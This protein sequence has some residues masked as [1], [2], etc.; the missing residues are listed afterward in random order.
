MTSKLKQFFV[1]SRYA[2]LALTSLVCSVG[3]FGESAQSGKVLTLAV[4]IPLAGYSGSFDHF[5]YDRSRH[6][7][8]LAAEDH[9]TVDVFA[10]DGGR[11]LAA[12][13]GF[14]NPHSILTLPS[15]PTF[16]VTD[17]GESRSQLI[18]ASTLKKIRN[19][20]LALGANCLLYDSERKLAYIT[21]GG[22]RVGMQHSSL[23]TVEPKDGSE[24]KSVQVAALHLQPMALDPTTNR[25]F[26]N[27]ADQNAV[28]IFDRRTLRLLDQWKITSGGRNSP[29]AFDAQHHRLFVV[30]DEPGLLIVFNSDSGKITNTVRV[31]GD[32]DDLDFDPVSHRLFIPGE[33]ALVVLDATNPD[34]VTEISRITTGKG[35]HTGLLL[36]Q[37]HKYLL[38][39]P[40]QG[41]GEPAHVAIFDVH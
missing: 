36:A 38:A 5:A 24:L 18:S 15:S 7:F 23:I 1:L 33:G 14:Q 25:L 40:S 12:I 37:E 28:A 19:L 35:A 41:K 8:F 10:L 29:I 13:G 22:D 26:V 2:A 32:A 20:P 30:C 9:G 4:S 39:V 17:S 11:H 34:H 21:A 6:W 3:C 31:P 27:L 16:L